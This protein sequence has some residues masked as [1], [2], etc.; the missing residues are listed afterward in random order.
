MSEVTMSRAVI[1]IR[2]LAVWVAGVAAAALAGALPPAGPDGRIAC[3][4]CDL[5][6]ADLAGRDL[7]Y[8]NFAGAD[9]AGANLNG[10]N[11]GGAA[12]PGANLTG[13]DLRNA[14]FDAATDLTAA[15]LTNA[16]MTGATLGGAVF[17]FATLTGADRSGIGF[18]PAHEA[19]ASGRY[20][21]GARDTTGLPNVRYVAPGG[22][23]NATCGASFQFPCATIER[24]IMNCSGTECAVLVAY[25][26]YKL[27]KPLRLTGGVSVYGGCAMLEQP[28]P[29]LRS[30]LRGPVGAPAV[31]APQIVTTTVFHGFSVFAGAGRNAAG[32]TASVA[33][34]SIGSSG[35]VLESVSLSAGAASRAPDTR[36]GKIPPKADNGRGQ[37]PGVSPGNADGGSGGDFG[38]EGLPGEPGGTP[39]RARGGTFSN[40]G[41]GTGDDGPCRGPGQRSTE[42]NGS[43]ISS[44]WAP[45][46]A[47]AGDKGGFG[48]GG[49]GGYGSAGR[50]GGGGGAGGEGG[51]G[52]DGATQGGAS[53]ALL[54]VGGRLSYTSGAIRAGVGGSGNRGGGGASR[55]VPGDGGKVKGIAGNGGDGGKGGPGAGGAGGNGGPAFSVV[56]AGTSDDDGVFD[57]DRKLV[58]LYGG[59]PGTPGAGGPA[60]SPCSEGMN[61]LPGITRGIQRLEIKQP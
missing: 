32:E 41:G 2:I 39:N 3:P 59:T 33:F 16:R 28:R 36:D 21:C 5:R 43:I 6:Q 29:E 42:V 45:G 35:V 49:G 31:V 51:G 12:L 1:A 48:G 15:N 54:I 22:A 56:T 37:S 60:P 26:E 20:F 19:T 47:G 44:T 11:L 13:A 14:V 52:G 40:R 24:G 23:D 55:G 30:L 57:Y 50:V 8:A 17:N 9:L 61:G 18:E 53:I 38:Q 27:S 34:A 46:V 7:R 10:A 4:Y 58:Q 25:A